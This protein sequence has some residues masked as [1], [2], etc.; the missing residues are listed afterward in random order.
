MTRAADSLFKVQP[1]IGITACLDDRGRWKPDRRYVYADLAY[2]GAVERAGGVPLLLPIQECAEALID[3]VDAI[4]LPGGDDFAAPHS[5]PP[6]VRFDPAPGPQLDFD[7]GLLEAAWQRQLP[8]LGICYGMQL[9]ALQ[10]GGSLHYH[11][12][13]DLPEAARHH[14][15]EADG[16]HDLEVES[17]TR[18]AAILG[19]A[20][21]PVNS[22]HHQ[23]V[24]EPGRGMRV[25]ARCS[26]GVIE[27]IETT[28]PG[29]GIGVQWH[30]ERLEC[31]AS[32]R[33]FAAFVE[34]ARVR[35]CN[36]PGRRE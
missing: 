7:R 33:L 21:G 12:P 19:D 23:A 26:D 22:L 20:A 5:Y 17:G 8:I 15:P 28:E 31:P 3:R 13:V 25:S 36:G 9:L 16:R 34:A 27:A 2:A 18:L 11:L 1:V 29:F 6:E 35:A 30:P 14:L 10:R 32:L 24:A 4:L